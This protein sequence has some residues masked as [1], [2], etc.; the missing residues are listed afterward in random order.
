MEPDIREALRYM[1]IRGEPDPALTEEMAALRA[2]LD[3]LEALIKA[4]ETREEEE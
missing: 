1:G 3:A 2:R 4:E